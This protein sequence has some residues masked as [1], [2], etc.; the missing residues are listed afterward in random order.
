MTLKW[1]MSMMAM[2]SGLSR[3]APA[4]AC[5]ASLSRA[6]PV[7]QAGQTILT[8]QSHQLL[9]IAAVD[10]QKVDEQ[11]DHRDARHDHD[12]VPAQRQGLTLRLF[13]RDA[14]F[15]L[16]QRVAL[17]LPIRLEARA[18]RRCLLDPFGV[19]RRCVA[20]QVLGEVGVRLR[21]VVQ[22]RVGLANATCTPKRP[23]A[24]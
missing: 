7:R 23:G 17:Y 1:S 4:S 18:Q 15:A 13:P 24:A 5:T 19:V 3:V 14:Q 22:G 21:V 6:A 2:V 20:P 12:R 16:Q 11:R 10:D 9:P 8:G